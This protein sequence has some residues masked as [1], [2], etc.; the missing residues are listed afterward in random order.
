MEIRKKLWSGGV[1][2]VV[3]IEQ[4]GNSTEQVGLCETSKQQTKRAY[5]KKNF[6][7]WTDK[8]KKRE[9]KKS[10]QRKLQ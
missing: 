8:K 3:P 10:R 4:I 6:Q 7:Y 1:L 5:T 9:I 2:E